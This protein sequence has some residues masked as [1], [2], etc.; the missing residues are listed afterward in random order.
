MRSEEW[1]LIQDDWFPIRRGRD[2]RYVYIHRKEYERIKQEGHC[3]QAR[4][5]SCKR[6]QPDYTVVLDF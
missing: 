4:E 6:N 1:A 3:L 2:T 5:T